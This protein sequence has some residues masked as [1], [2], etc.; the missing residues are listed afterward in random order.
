MP[1]APLTDVSMGKVTIFS[2][3][4]G[5]I[6]EAAVI[7]TTVGAL[8]SGKTSTSVVVVIQVPPMSRIKPS[9]RTSRR[10][11]SEYDIIL[12]SIVIVNFIIIPLCT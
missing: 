4:S 7:T 11:L 10:L 1:V 5:A 8:R 12:F 3:S 9:I 2:T 6:P